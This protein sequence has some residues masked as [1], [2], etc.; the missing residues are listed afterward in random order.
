MKANKFESWRKC[1]CSSCRPDPWW[2]R[3]RVKARDQERDFRREVDEAP[4]LREWQ[5][6]EGT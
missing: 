4:M 3:H 5:A 6:R 2:A 1:R